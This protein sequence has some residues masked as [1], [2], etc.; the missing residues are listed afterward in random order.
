MDAKHLLG[1]STVLRALLASTLVRGLVVAFIAVLALGS[2]GRTLTVVNIGLLTLGGTAIGTFIAA[3]QGHPRRGLGLIPLA[4]TGLCISM[5]VSIWLPLACLA[6]GIMAGVL[7]VTLVSAY[8]SALPEKS[9]GTATA[10]LQALGAITVGAV[11]LTAML[12]RREFL[13]GAT[14]LWSIAVLT[15]L[16]AVIAWRFLLREVIEQVTELVLW[17]IYRIRAVGPGVHSCPSHGPALI[18]AN[19]SAYL[20][21]LWLGKVVPRR[22]VPMMTSA[23]YD[24]PLM[25][26][27]MNRVVRAVRVPTAS[28]RREAPELEEA[29]AT[30]DRGD[31]LVIFP[32]AMLRRREDQPLRPFGQG[33]WHILRERPATPVIP[34]WIEGGWGSY[35]SYQNG[36]PTKNKRWDW[37]RPIVVGMS[38]PAIMSAELLA[39][40]RATRRHL[41]EAVLHARSYTEKGPRQNPSASAPLPG[42]AGTGLTQTAQAPKPGRRFGCA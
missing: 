16:V 40:Q 12:G 24:L 19:H 15:G 22:L 33:V 3:T 8:Q 14:P 5:A 23:F 37:W 38:E 32:E 39:D 11:A 35:F 1:R 28:F 17:P 20:D 29:V 4:M 25:R 6:V 31:C 2:V 10:I 21:P 9:E 41:Q 42:P 26:W 27:L 7:H 36:P 18:V 30:L 13:S 34:C